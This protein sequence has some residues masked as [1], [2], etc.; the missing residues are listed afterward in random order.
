MSRKPDSAKMY[1]PVPSDSRCGAYIT[2]QSANKVTNKI[3]AM[4][5]CIEQLVVA[6]R[7]KNPLEETIALTQMSY[8]ALQLPNYSLAQSYAQDALKLACEHKLLDWQCKVLCVLAK[9]AWRSNQIRFSLQYLEQACKHLTT[10]R[11]SEIIFEI[12]FLAGQVWFAL[13][14]F[15]TARRHLEKAL[16][17]VPATERAQQF[18]VLGNLSTTCASLGDRT[19]ALEY[20]SQGLEVA[21]TGEARG[22]MLMQLAALYSI[23]HDY[24]HMAEYL[25]QAFDAWSE[26]AINDKFRGL[27]GFVVKEILDTPEL[28]CK[29][30]IPSWVHMY[31]SLPPKR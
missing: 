21:P 23:D 2:D 1:H 6:R 5:N 8:G 3:N 27:F 29:V 24:E 25:H 18:R 16:H 22:L 31:L 26:D 19:S 14:D 10:V 4:L 20:A 30:Q 28:A 11:N 15:R 13:D 17:S 7:L 12:N 9:I